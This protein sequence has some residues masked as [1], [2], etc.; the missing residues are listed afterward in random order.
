MSDALFVCVHN[1]GRSQMA[2]AVFDRTVRERGLLLTSESA[3]THPAD[4]VH[5]AIAEV[6][7]EQGIDVS[8]IVPRLITDEMVQTAGRVITMGCAIDADKCPAI[9]LRGVEDWGLP[10]PAN[11]GIE[12]AIALHQVVE[13]KVAELVAELS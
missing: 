9:Y 2:R 8:G 7:R 13:K 12:E 1:A 10:D 4:N 6:L 5:E 3:G 11:K